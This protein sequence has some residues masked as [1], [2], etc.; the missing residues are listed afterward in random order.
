MDDIATDAS[1]DCK[2]E[3][4]AGKMSLPIV[5]EIRTK[6]R[7]GKTE[8][9]RQRILEESLKLFL[10]QGYEKTT[11]RQILQRVGILNGSLYN[12]YRN[13]EAIFTDIILMS[14]REVMEQAPKHIPE[15]SDKIDLLTYLLCIEIYLSKRS[16]RI[17]ELLC[18][19]NENWN[20]RTKVDAAVL[21]WARTAGSVNDS[22]SDID[23]PLL[24]L[25][26]CTGATFMFIE[27]MANEAESVDERSAMTIVVEFVNAL[28]HRADVD[29]DS[30]VSSLIASFSREEIVVCGLR[31]LRGTGM[32]FSIELT[33]EEED[34][35]RNYASIRGISLEEAFK[36]ALFDRI[37]D[38]YDAAVGEAA[39]RE[40]LEDPRTYTLEEIRRDVEGA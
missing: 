13:K 18:I 2:R 17:A 40:Y 23:E 10:E 22:Y 7:Y 35:A 11:T 26:A 6:K 31:V 1:Q 30:K 27:M 19:A 9:T 38:E 33:A 25:N 24:R 12:I 39:Y 8:E 32:S 29:V 5:T 21:D 15:T 37:E 3:R 36:Q 14:L 20:V 28:A 34:L 16:K 4:K